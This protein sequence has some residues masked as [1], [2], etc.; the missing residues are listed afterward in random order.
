MGP[1]LAARRPAARRPSC[2]AS[3]ATGRTRSARGSRPSCATR[4]LT[5]SPT[6]ASSAR[7]RAGWSAPGPAP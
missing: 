2:C 6:K 7:P 4:W 3:G 1:I 5:S